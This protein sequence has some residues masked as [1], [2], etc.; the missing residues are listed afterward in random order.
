MIAP[1]EYVSFVEREYLI[2][3]IR[4]GGSAVKFVVAESD[5]CVSELQHELRRAAE[6]AGYA[7]AAV[8]AAKVKVHMIDKVFHE[9]AR[10][11]D[12]R[13]LARTYSARAL[14]SLGFGPIDPDARIDLDVI[15]DAHDYRPPEL[16]REFKRELQKEI[17]EDAEMAHE[18]RIAM[19]RVCA[20]EVESD[21]HATAER[22][23]V[24][25]WLTGEIR[26]MSALKAAMIFQRVARH[27]ARD[28]LGSLTRWVASTG[29]GGLVLELDIRRCALQRR[30]DEEG[31]IYSKASTID[32]YEV[33]RQL[34]DSTDEL[35]HCFVV[36]IASPETL[37]DPRRGIADH[38]Q[39]LKMRIWN[40]V[41]DRERDNPLAALVRLSPE[42]QEHVNG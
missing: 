28:M 24:L 23:A 33:L 32:V 29:H 35:T 22:D 41:H 34:I 15:A 30:T 21:A 39:A 31:I 13:A 12:W 9:I 6:R 38:Y 5:A 2:D 4:G 40:E 10:Q 36:V 3:F 25:Q 11:T 7:Y 1:R 19:L 18:F 37:V 16:R 42:G 17:L 26:L 20:A 27:N 14:N 8:D